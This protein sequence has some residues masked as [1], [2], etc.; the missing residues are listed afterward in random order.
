MIRVDKKIRLLSVAIV[1]L[2]FVAACAGGP[3]G[4]GG[5]GGPGRGGPPGGGFAKGPG[6][7]PPQQGDD[8]FYSQAL[9]LKRDGNCAEAVPL[10]KRVAEMGQ[11]YE[12]AQYHLG[13]CLLKTAATKGPGAQADM[14]N[15]LAMHWLLKAA[16]SNNADA[17]G[18]LTA[19]YL[20]GKVVGVDRVEAAKWYLLY[21]RNP[22]QV[23][24]G[25]TA[26]APGVEQ[27]LLDELR[28]QEWAAAT[29]EA[30]SW[31]VVQQDINRRD[32]DRG[33]PGREGGGRDRPRRLTE[34]M[35]AGLAG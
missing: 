26:L 28:P 3:S 21:M 27:F 1:S 16:H 31:Q 11:G 20:D 23:K 5:P 29:A 18:K 2:F 7:P 25:A 14:D 9:E 35:D 34:N 6:G 32:L 17:Q 33:G 4:G 12:I 13:D 22:I 19:I 10:F 30:D 24:V 15:A 8:R